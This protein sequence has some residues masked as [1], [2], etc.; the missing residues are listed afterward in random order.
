[1]L[2]TVF[3]DSVEAIYTGG[4]Y[5]GTAYRNERKTCWWPISARSERKIKSS[6]I[7]KAEDWSGSAR[8]AH[9]GAW[10]ERLLKT[11]APAGRHA[12]AYQLSAQRAKSNGKRQT[13]N[14]SSGMAHHHLVRGWDADALG[15][16][17]NGYVQLIWNRVIFIFLN[18]LSNTPLAGLF[19][20][21]LHS[22]Y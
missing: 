20:Y 18:K 11:G 22:F 16:S 4:V 3:M 15:F 1:M 21:A 14:A 10:H 8:Q 19:Q 9:F 12:N 5:D 6:P 2:N 13:D 7:I 17:V